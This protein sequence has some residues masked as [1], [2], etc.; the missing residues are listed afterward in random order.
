[1]S[2]SKN[3]LVGGLLL[4]GIAGC[5]FLLPWDRW[6]GSAPRHEGR[7]TERIAEYVKLRQLE[8][9]PGVY[10][11]TALSDR[12]RV[13]L[14]RYLVLYGLGAIKANGIKEKVRQVDTAK[15]TAV[16]EL[17]LDGELRLDRLSPQVRRSLGPQDPKNLVKVSDFTT[18]WAWIDGDWWLRMDRE[19]LTGVNSDGKQ[20]TPAGN[21]PTDNTPTG[22]K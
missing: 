1:M 11:L 3:G 21:T 20:I 5:L 6:M 15:G 7:L 2:F 10:A 16:V 14:A 17:T 22:K 9:W 13:P 4:A 18:E 12:Q 8:D 19:A